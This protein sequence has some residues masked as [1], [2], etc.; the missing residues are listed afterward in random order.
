MAAADIIERFSKVPTQQKVLAFGLIAL[1]IGAAYYFLIHSDLVDQVQGQTTK[2]S[3]LK[4]EK[5]GYEA[6][7]QKYMAF[8]A[9]VNKL[10]QMQKELVKALPTEADIHTLLQSI[11]AQGELSGLNILT[12]EQNAEVKSEFYAKIPVKMVISGSF[13]QILKFFYSVGQLKRIVNIT[14]LALSNPKASD[15]GVLI[16]ANFVAST[17]RF[18]TMEPPRPQ[19][20]P[21]QAQPPA[22]APQPHG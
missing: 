9:E 7:K 4:D 14:D 18:L 22:P 19:G 11:H 15:A 5:S 16:Q 20:Q 10:L 21:Q 17:F 8:R 12:F 6:K 3:Q 1:A 2:I 13:H